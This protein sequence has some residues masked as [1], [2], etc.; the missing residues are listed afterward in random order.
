[1]SECSK[2][3][4]R[5]I[6]KPLVIIASS[7]MGCDP[8]HGWPHV[9]RV[10]SYSERIVENERLRV[11]WKVLEASI[12]LHDIGRFTP[13]SGHHAEKSASLAVE[14]LSGLGMEDIVGE[15]RHAILAHSY[16]LGVK[17]KSVEA[18]VLSDAD[19]L[20]ALG[21][22]GIARVIHTGC[23]MGR[24]FRESLSHFYEKILRLPDRMYFDYSRRLAEKLVVRVE[25]YI[26]ALE[27]EMGMTKH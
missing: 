26:E 5:V 21:A 23:Q 27:E 16:S 15:V 18:K 4:F 17:P 12:A 10:Y 8:A 20:D 7:I 22:I 25:N 3:G 19:K 2:A 13:G 14:F 9:A 24:S 1:M 11:D 6:P